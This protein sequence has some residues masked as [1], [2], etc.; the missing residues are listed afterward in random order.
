MINEALEN[1]FFQGKQA[2]C[3]KKTLQISVELSI[4]LKSDIFC[5]K[6]AFFWKLADSLWFLVEQSNFKGISYFPLIFY[7][8]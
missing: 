7:K 8:I 1:S 6:R 4:L 5:A 2:I 3:R